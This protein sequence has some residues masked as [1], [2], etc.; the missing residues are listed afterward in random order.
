M[1]HNNR[2]TKSICQSDDISFELHQ[3]LIHFIATMHQIVFKTLFLIGA[4]SFIAHFTCAQDAKERAKVEKEADARAKAAKRAKAATEDDESHDH[5]HD[6]SDSKKQAKNTSYEFDPLKPTGVLDEIQKPLSNI[7][8]IE[9]K[10]ELLSLEF[11]PSYSEANEDFQKIRSKMRGGGGGHGSGDYWTQY[12]SGYN[13]GGQMQKGTQRHFGGGEGSPDQFEAE[14][15]ESTG[16][17]R[18]MNL[19][20][21]NKGEFVLRIDGGLDPYLLQVQQKKNRFSVQE[22]NGIEAFAGKATSFEGFC[23][24]YPDFVL[25]RMLPVL[26]KYGFSPPIT[27]FNSVTRDYVVDSLAPLSQDRVDAFMNEYSDL[28]SAEFEVREAATKRL[29]KDYT[30]WKDLIRVGVASDSFSLELR[31]RLQKIVGEQSGDSGKELISLATSA[32]LKN[33]PEYLLWLAEQTKDEQ[34]K[35]VVAQLEKVTGKDFGSDLAA[36]KKLIGQKE[37]KGDLK[38]ENLAGNPLVEVKAYLPQMAV[39]TADLLRLRVDNNQLKL[40]RKYWSDYF[41]GEKIETIVKRVRAEMEKSN[42]PSR[43]LNPAGG[44]SLKNVFHEHVLFENIQSAIPAALSHNHYYYGNFSN[45]RRSQI[46]RFVEQNHLLMKLDRQTVEKSDR[47]GTS[48]NSKPTTFRYHA[49]ERRDTLMSLTVTEDEDVGFS[50]TISGGKT[51]SLFQLH[52]QKNGKIFCALLNGGKS[53]IKSAETYSELYRLETE[54]V[55]Q[56]I[57]PIFAR[58]GI[59]IPASIGGPLEIKN[60]PAPKSSN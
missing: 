19:N 48:K 4:I 7:L 38:E 25:S 2:I 59:Q 18:E 11:P 57:N 27:R 31:S 22:V 40:D 28:E 24:D 9:R 54:F 55:T 39:P 50:I 20:A 42:L 5:S 8:K 16:R 17:A 30:K 6:H 45:Y 14:I 15:L 33:D 58:F 32:D 26:K 13:A 44:Y 34:Q 37:T 56:K 3:T 23:R 46:N 35:H 51:D 12:F 43:W 21:E 41:K 29:S 47:G 10:G 52:Q 60:G 49:K 36:W 53:T 1:V